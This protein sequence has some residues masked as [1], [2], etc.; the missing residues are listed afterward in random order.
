M[1]AS[2]LKTIKTENFEEFEAAIEQFGFIL[3]ELVSER[4][5]HSEHGDIED[6]LAAHDKIFV[7][8]QNRDAQLRTLLINETDCEKDKLISVRH[9]DG[10]PIGAA[11]LIDAVSEYSQKS[12]AA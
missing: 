5:A 11:V 12:A 3:N 10:S 7:L 2:Y 6:F 9:Y 4:K 1:S 8:D